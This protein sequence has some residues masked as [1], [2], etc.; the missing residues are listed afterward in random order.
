MSVGKIFSIS[1]EGVALQDVAA[2]LTANT[3][4]FWIVTANPE[5]LLEARKQPTYAE[6]LHKANLRMVDGFGLWL[7]LRLFGYKTKRVTGVE[8]GEFLLQL[9][10]VEHW[11]VAF[12]GGGAGIAQRAA[13]EIQKAYPD[14]QIHT[15][16]GGMVNA[17]GSDDA[18]GIEARNRIKTFAPH[19]LLVA[20]GHPK[21]EMWIEKHLNEFSSLKAIVGVGGTFDYWSGE[22][23]RAPELLR[24]FGLE[25]LWRVISEPKRWK[26][27]LNAV[28][29]FPVLAVKE[30]MTK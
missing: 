29:V 10:H 27:I 17:D 23:K 14:L 18:Q 4:P 20:F 21:Q 6:T 13:Q 28:I 3:Q 12:I 30:R 7:V 11:K 24:A 16:E 8:L 15:E 5:I 2:K 22:K 1:V 9:A 25:W 26:R 19:I